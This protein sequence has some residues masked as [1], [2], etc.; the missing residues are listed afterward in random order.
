MLTNTELNQIEKHWAVASIDTAKKEKAFEFLNRKLVENS[1]SSYVEL[2]LKEANDY[3]DTLKKLS[4]A[5]E[6]AALEGLKYFTNSSLDNEDKKKS[7]IAGSWKAY[8]V[9][10]VLPIPSSIK[11]KIFYILHLSSLAYCGDRWSDLKR[12]YLDINVE[13]FVNIE[14]ESSWE[15]ILLYRV[16]NCWIH[17]F[18]KNNWQDLNSI[19]QTISDLRSE[20]D[21]YEA[22]FLLNNDDNPEHVSA[23]QLVSLYHWAKATE[24]LAEYMLQGTPVDARTKIDKHFESAIEAAM[25]VC[26]SRLEIMFRWLHAS[27]IQMINGSIWKTARN[28]SSTTLKFIDKL[29]KTQSLFELLPPQKAAIREQGLLDAS[30]I[31]VAVELPTSGGK[32]LLAQFKMLQALNQFDEDRGWVAYIAPTKALA[33]QITRRLRRDFE[34]IGIKVE[35]LSGAIDIDAIEEELLSEDDGSSHFDVLVSTPEKLQLV[36]RNNKIKRPLALVVMD[37][38]HNIENDSRG[39]RIE[40]LLASIKRECQG[41]NFLLLMPYV[42]NP[43]ALTSWLAD[44]SSAG[45]SISIGSTPWKPNERVVGMYYSSSL[46]DKEKAE[47]KISNDSSWRLKFKTLVTTPKTI[48]LDGEHKVGPIK[49]LDVTKGKVYNKVKNEQKN[50]TLQTAAIAKIFSERGTSIAVTNQIRSTWTM[51]REIK[52]ALGPLPFISENI[53][54]VQ[55]FLETEVSK[56]FELIEMLSCGIAVHNAGLSDETRALIEWL[57]EKD[58]LK[59]L[60][61]TSTIA[62][63]INFPVSSVFLSSKY[64]RTKKA[65]FP[66]K[67][68]DFWNLA[69][70]AGRIGQDSVGVVGIAMGTNPDAIASYVSEATGELVSRIEKMLD[71][72]EK[73]GNLNELSNKIYSDQWEDFRCYVAH[74]WSEKKNIDEVLGET[75]QLLRNT[76]GYQSLKSRDNGAEKA[77]ALLEAT[78]NYAKS[79][80]N[81]PGITELAD[82]TGFSPEGVKKA[83]TGIKNLEYSLSPKNLTPDGLLGE[84]ESSMSDLYGIML[85]VP[86]LSNSLEELVGT[87]KESK[88]IAEVTNAW[89]NG[90]SIEDIAKAYFEDEDGTKA[91][92]K[93]CRAIYRTLVNNGTWGI[94]AISKISG[95]DFE[96]LSESEKRKINLM[97]SMIYHGVNSEDA[98]L[99]RMNNTPRSISENLSKGLRGFSGEKNV[100][101]RVARDYI[102][103]LNES[104]WDAARPTGAKLSGRDYKEIWE[105]LAGE[106]S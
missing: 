87:G 61:A 52:K 70:R 101:S 47:N 105:L 53:K 85:K 103:S 60:C 39:L 25:A 37:E 33:S 29:T 99:M 94:S 98:V 82:L 54:L 13:P 17:L 22:K 95:I 9:K 5:Y 40:L 88:Y 102:K 78:K 30:K 23:I 74:L 58:E 69:G 97:P 8:E 31:A 86:Q 56:D 91:I 92:T 81:S 6:L 55:R 24:I 104:D 62:Q 93:A 36:I 67:T 7:F 76:Y 90:S 19:S 42:D 34:P 89:V 38:A 27:S 68:R 48:H 64:V 66:M 49:P 41:A 96:K 4:L 65:S 106:K 2:D 79:L 59:V 100:T 51:A 11:D 72:I 50:A 43:K 32:T 44:D 45:R 3:T 12:W 16:Y 18:R 28:V 57:A 46:T 26:D 73:A 77:K 63:G 84:G 10:R 35:Q 1:L 83:M 15:K 21:K 80:S 75:E 20:Q 14:K 71:D